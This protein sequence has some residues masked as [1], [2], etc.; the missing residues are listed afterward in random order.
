VRRRISRYACVRRRT[1]VCLHPAP[2][3]AC[4]NRKTTDTEDDM[5]ASDF[6]IKE[7]YAIQ[8]IQVLLFKALV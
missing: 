7:L 4:S 2:L 8:R 5:D 1:A 3:T 6:T